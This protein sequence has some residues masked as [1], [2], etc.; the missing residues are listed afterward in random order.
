[1]FFIFTKGIFIIFNA[2]RM[3]FYIKK[4]IPALFDSQVFIGGC[5][6]VTFYIFFA[7]I[8]KFIF[9]TLKEKIKEKSHLNV[10]LTEAE[11]CDRQSH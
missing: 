7:V 6:T 8:I 4:K 2:V 1:V 5:E 9:L 10:M 3:L 11:H